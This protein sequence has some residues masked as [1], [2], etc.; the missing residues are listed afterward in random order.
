MRWYKTADHGDTLQGQR[1]SEEMEKALKAVSRLKDQVAANG[2]DVL[3]RWKG[4]LRRR[5]LLL[6][7]QERVARMCMHELE[8]LSSRT[9]EIERDI[10]KYDA[11]RGT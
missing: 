10:A 8:E 5:I 1:L 3:G 6:P 11:R 4:E 2:P 7:P 9:D